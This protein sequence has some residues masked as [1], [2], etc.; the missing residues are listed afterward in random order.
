M[1]IALALFALLG[2][3]CWRLFD[4]VVRVQRAGAEQALAL[5]SLQRG[6][7]VVE[8]DVL[9]LEGPSLHLGPEGLRLTRG[10]W[11]NPL[12]QPRS[13]FQPVHYGL[14][15]GRMLR[16]GHAYGGAPQAQ[17]LLADVQ[18]LQWRVRDQDGHWHVRWPSGGRRAVALELSLTT[19]RYP[20]VRRLWLLPGGPP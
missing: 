7:A 8:R 3:A 6:L 11:A 5:R 13:E 14:V 1:L 17:R 2:V 19:A 9:H 16:E 20:N 12:R 15:A 10:N 4:T 18:R